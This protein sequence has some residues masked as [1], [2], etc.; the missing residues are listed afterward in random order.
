MKTLYSFFDRVAGVFSAPFVGERKEAVIRGVKLAIEQGGNQPWQVYPD[1]NDLFAIG[2]G[3]STSDRKNA[4]VVR[5]GDTNNNS[6]TYL[7]TEGNI[8]IGSQSTANKV[9]T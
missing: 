5:K 4:L 2:C 1:D 3:S 8:Y 7:I 6:L 9:I